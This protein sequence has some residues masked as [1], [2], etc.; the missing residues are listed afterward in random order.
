MAFFGI[1]CPQGPGFTESDT[2]R[3]HVLIDRTLERAHHALELPEVVQQLGERAAFLTDATNRIYVPTIRHGFVEWGDMPDDGIP[4]IAAAPLEELTLDQRYSRFSPR[5]LEAA[6]TYARNAP[7][8][9]NNPPRVLQYP[10]SSV[11]RTDWQT[12]LPYK[13]PNDIIT[14]FHSDMPVIQLNTEKRYTK[15][16]GLIEPEAFIHEIAHAVQAEMVPIW[17]QLR[18]DLSPPNTHSESLSREIEAYSVGASVTRGLHAA[19]EYHTHSKVGKRSIAIE[20]IAQSIND[21]DNPWRSSQALA[22]CL[23][24]KGHS[25]ISAVI[26]VRNRIIE[27]PS[28][29]KQWARFDEKSTS[30]FR[31]RQQYP[32]Q[33]A[34]EG[35]S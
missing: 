30:Q 11:A 7:R 27:P 32:H 6:D 34:S 31:F 8:L 2:R 21:I 28:V 26:P 9:I 1:K 25:D 23:A 10:K 29:K 24:R 35:A 13:D 3:R 14:Y 17:L 16:K 19:G 4:L 5:Q 20:Q 12:R 33:S 18:P 22:R 15:S